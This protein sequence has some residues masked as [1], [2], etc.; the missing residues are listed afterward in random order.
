MPAPPQPRII[1]MEVTAYCP[2]SRCC[3]PNA[4]G[5][6]A[7]GEHVSANDGRFVAADTSLPFGT[8]I[9]IPGYADAPV[10]VLDRGGAIRG[11]RLDVY[12]DS[13]EAALEWGR[14]TLDVAILDNP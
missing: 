8:R 2:C 11:N 14:Q 5:I 13:H 7:S 9:I 12:F 1:R 6:T 3:G 4:A 10:P